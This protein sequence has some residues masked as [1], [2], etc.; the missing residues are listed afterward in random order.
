MLVEKNRIRLDRP[1]AARVRDLIDGAGSV[2]R[3]L[4]I[5]AQR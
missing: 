5:N 2:I 3:R 1:T 4:G